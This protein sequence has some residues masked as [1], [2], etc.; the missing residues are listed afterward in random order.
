MMTKLPHEIEPLARL[1]ILLA[2]EAGE[3]S[4]GQAAKALQV[5]VVKARA[6]KQRMIETGKAAAEIL[7]RQQPP[8][9][10]GE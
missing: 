3:L 7:L 8:V 10:K 6:T 4:E 9:G 2:W 1:M 5:P